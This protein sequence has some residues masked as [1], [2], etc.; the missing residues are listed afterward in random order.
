LGWERAAQ[1][2]QTNLALVCISRECYGEK[3]KEQHASVVLAVNKKSL[4]VQSNRLIE[5]KYRLSVEEQ[6]IIKILI[7][8]IQRD[9]ED[10]KDYEFRIKDLAEMLDMEHKDPYGVLRAITKR[11]MTRVLEFFN[12]ETQS[13]L[14]TAWLSSAEYKQGRG[15]V[16]LCFDPKMKPLL[17]QLQSYFTK[18]EL[19]QVLQF[20]GQYT[21]RFFEFRKSFLGRRKK[22]TVLT[23]KEL[24]DT[25]GL[26]K[27]EYQQFF[28]FKK[29]VL[30]PARLEL[31][32]KTGSSFTWEPLRQGRGGKVA[33]IRFVFDGGHQAQDRRDEEATAP[34][35]AP[36]GLSEAPE[37][38]SLLHDPSV[39]L[40]VSF[41]V[42]SALAREL[43]Q[44]HEEG[45]LQ[46]K[47]AIVAARPDSVKN[48]AGFLI[49]A[50][51]EDWKDPRVEEKKRLAEVR[52]TEREQH[53]RQAHLRAIKQDFDRCRKA[54]ALE[55]YEQ[56]PESTRRR[57]QEEFLA[58]LNP[59]FQKR[60]GD[61]P[62]FGFEDPYY[63]AFLMQEKVLA[64]SLES[65]LQQVG[66]ALTPEDLETLSRL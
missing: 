65:Y 17:L 11:L 54:Q 35:A 48:K 38:E 32:E 24:R 52:R 46:E 22:E 19:G 53:E 28:D 13:L 2:A 41:G 66:I 25:L 49:A 51:Q 29:R 55:Q 4:I 33:A 56:F 59:I 30:E 36:G 44:Q 21:I 42:S 3:V 45:Y 43:A 6:K 1:L 57:F 40:L 61:K 60:Y 62:E 39:D 5:A 37:E 47:I 16:S 9:D 64:P 8:Q 15:T 63:R 14:Q 50:I 23:L 31:M 7:S 12:P 18:Y 10:F 58:T 27:Q 20:K 34:D 26:K